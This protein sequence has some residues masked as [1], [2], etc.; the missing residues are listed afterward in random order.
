MISETPTLPLSVKSNQYGAFPAK[1]YYYIVD[2]NGLIF[3]QD[4]KW[5][6]K[7]LI[8][9]TKYAYRTESSALISL[10]YLKERFAPALRRPGRPATITRETNRKQSYSVS[11]TPE[12]YATLT[13]QYGSLTNALKT[14]LP[15]LLLIIAL[16]ACNVK[17][18]HEYKYTVWVGTAILSIGY[19]TDTITYTGNDLVFKD[20]EGL[21]QT[22]DK[23]KVM[24]VEEKP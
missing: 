8:E 11:I 3:H 18:V 10:E 15:I 24:H 13:N 19:E 9:I 4:K 1:T 16:S 22:F 23:S 17:P 20:K 7:C 21:K 12:Q 2:A 14:L 6:S 5:R